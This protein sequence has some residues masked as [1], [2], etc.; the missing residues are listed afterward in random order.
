MDSP[1]LTPARRWAL[2]AALLH[3]A[4]V[5]HHVARG[6]SIRHDFGPS[7]WDWFWQNLTTADLR[8]RA[9][10]SLWHLHAQPPL[11]N[12]LNV[13]LIKVFGESHPEVLFFLHVVMGAGLTALAVLL[14]ARLTGSVWAGA[15]AGLLVALDP[16]LVL[17]EAYALY[18]LLCALLILGACYAAARAGPEGRT[19]PLLTAVAAISAL[20][21]TRSAYHLVLLAPVIFGVTALARRRGL[22]LV[23][24]VALALAPAGWYAKNLVQYGFFGGSSWYGMGLW[25]VALFRYQSG[26]LTPLLENGALDPVVTIRP[27]SPPSRYRHLGYTGESDVPSLS[28][29]DLRNVNVPAISRGYARSARSLALHDPV[30]FLGNAMIGYGNFSAPSTEFDHLAPDR[31]RMGFHV[32]AWRVATGL[33]L[34]RAVDARLPIGTVGSVFALLIP[35]GL[36]AQIVLSGRRL[37]RGEGLERVLREEAALVCAALFVAYTAVVGSAAELGEN[38]R[39]KFMIEPLL[40]TWWTALAVR[41]WRSWRDAGVP[42]DTDRAW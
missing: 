30:H 25:R 23:A 27:L 19:A 1:V 26:E 37:R 8:D 39:F 36:I 7:T 33:P 20:V 18:D 17:Y 21:L 13:P 3:I 9:L 31:E 42:S 12:A 32:T 38:V 4:V 41:G 35:L 10:E 5:G 24:S 11:W 16:A 40:L 28:R 14:A 2:G 6:V 15:L 34:V 29:D 22:V